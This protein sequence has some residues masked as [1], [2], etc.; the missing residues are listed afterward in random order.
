[1]SRSYKKNPVVKD[2]PKGSKKVKQLANRRFRRNFSEEYIKDY[3]RHT[4]TWEI[5][6]F[7]GRW[8]W[9]HARAEYESGQL[10]KWWYEK[11]PTLEEFHNYW[12]KEMLGK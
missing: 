7:I 1:M 9:E 12:R 3:K 10:S 11:C 5:H 2:N 4:D 8:G 6:D